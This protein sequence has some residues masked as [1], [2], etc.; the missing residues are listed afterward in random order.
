MRNH[1]ENWTT[2]LKLA[3][4]VKPIAVRG[5]KSLQS[6]WRTESGKIHG[7]DAPSSQHVTLMPLHPHHNLAPS[8]LYPM[9]VCCTDG[10]VCALRLPLSVPADSHLCCKVWG[11][12]KDS[13]QQL[14]QLS[15]SRRESCCRCKTKM[16]LK[17]IYVLCKVSKV[18]AAAHWLQDY[19]VTNSFTLP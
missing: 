13:K 2:N 16:V 6:L 11:P 19:S 8:L 4:P 3:K 18:L 17:M 12:P 9:L 7:K 5:G 10:R 1:R 15:C 14:A